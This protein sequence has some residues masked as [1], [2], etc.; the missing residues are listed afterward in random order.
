MALCQGLA[1]VSSP[2][3]ACVSVCLSIIY[4]VG[5][6]KFAENIK[7][8]T[9]Q[10]CLLRSAFVSAEPPFG[11]VIVAQNSSEEQ[12]VCHSENWEVKWDLMLGRVLLSF[13]F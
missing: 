3:Y 1:F 5:D 8:N 2:L 7:N 11:C 12:F 10:A 4:N 6:E 9:C 13:L